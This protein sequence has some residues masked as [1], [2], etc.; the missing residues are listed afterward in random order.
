MRKGEQMSLTSSPRTREALQWL[1]KANDDEKEAFKIGFARV[2]HNELSRLGDTHDVSKI[3]LKGG[4]DGA[5]GV[6]RILREALGD[7]AAKEIMDLAQRSK[8]ATRTFQGYGN[9][10]T[11]PLAEAMKDQNRFGSITGLLQMLRPMN[12]IEKVGEMVGDKLNEKRN[13]ELLKRL[14]IMSDKPNEMFGLLD[15]LQRLQNNRLGAFTSPGVNA[16]SGGALVGSGVGVAG[17]D[18]RNR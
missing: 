13:V 3:F 14:S 5:D 1:K 12:A 15:E 7:D 16:Y 8:V 10:Q 11:T 2:L 4:K 6:R 9:S 18:R 17:Q